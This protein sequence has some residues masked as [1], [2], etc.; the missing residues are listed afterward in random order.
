MKKLSVPWSCPSFGNSRNDIYERVGGDGSDIEGIVGYCPARP[1]SLITAFVIGVLLVLTKTK[2]GPSDRSAISNVGSLLAL[3]LAV[4][5]V[6][7]AAGQ[8]V[9][10]VLL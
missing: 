2:T 3:L 8:G 9:G 7:S 5:S 4:H 1:I 10:G 6:V